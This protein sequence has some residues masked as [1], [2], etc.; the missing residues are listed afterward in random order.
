[1]LRLAGADEWGCWAW[2]LLVGIPA[3][4]AS[5][6]MICER[7]LSPSHGMDARPA[8]RPYSLTFHTMLNTHT[9]YLGIYRY[10]TVSTYVRQRTYKQMKLTRTF[11]NSTIL[12]QNY[13]TNVCLCNTKGVEQHIK[14]V[15]MYMYQIIF[16]ILVRPVLLA[17]AAQ[18]GIRQ[19]RGTRD[20][21]S[22]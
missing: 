18:L 10:L 19:E 5:D 7:D 4:P 2:L 21:P 17:T 9:V 15:W 22:Q 14:Y 1:M 11:N 20:K 6:W 3:L 12:K 8:P 16:F 13:C